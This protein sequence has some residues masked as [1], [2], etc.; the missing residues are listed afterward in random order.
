MKKFFLSLVGSLFIVTAYAQNPVYNPEQKR[1]RIFPL[2]GDKSYIKRN[3]VELYPASA[4]ED[5]AKE[6]HFTILSL[7]YRY[8]D[9]SA[10]E[11]Q[12]ITANRVKNHYV[13]TSLGRKIILIAPAN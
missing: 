10:A 7:E 6:S 5:P 3:E 4:D 8:E 12:K 13:K 2:D 9:F 11:L 1:E